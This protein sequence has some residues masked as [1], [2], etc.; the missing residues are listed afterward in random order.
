MR[1]KLGDDEREGKESGALS[2]RGK[3]KVL[4]KLGLLSK[5]PSFTCPSDLQGTETWPKRRVPP[6]KEEKSP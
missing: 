6:L 3:P 1:K 2:N 4:V 5:R